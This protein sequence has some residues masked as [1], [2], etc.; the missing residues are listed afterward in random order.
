PPHLR[1]SAQGIITFVSGGIGV[2][3]GNIFAGRVV[4]RHRVGT[5]IDWHEVWQVPQVACLVLLVAFV[6]LFKPP[7]ERKQ[8]TGDRSQ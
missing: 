5:A 4:D 2:W 7:P 1:A 3:V 6:V 8:E